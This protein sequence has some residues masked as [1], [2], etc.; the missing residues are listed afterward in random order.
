MIHAF[1]LASCQVVPFQV[2]ARCQ[3]DVAECFSDASLAKKV[4]GWETK[5]GLT[6]MGADTWRWQSA[7][8]RGYAGLEL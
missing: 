6:E 3:R 5:F 1:E 8:P 2:V 7:H 4:S